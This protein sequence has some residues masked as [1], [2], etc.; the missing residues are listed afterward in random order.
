MR[1]T[2]GMLTAG[3]TAPAARGLATW[4]WLC[5]TALCV[6]ATEAAATDELSQRIEEAAR[7]ELV[8][9]GAPSMQIAVAH[10][11][12]VI[13]QGAYG[14]ADLEQKV[15]ANVHSRY[16]TASLSKWLTATAALALVELGKLDLDAPIQRYCPSFPAHGSPMTTRHLLRHESGIRHELDHEAAIER[17]ADDAARLALEVRRDRELLSEYTRYTDVIEPLDVFKQDA[18]LFEPGTNWSYSS[19]GYRVA[20]CVLEGASSRPYSDLIRELIL[21]RSMMKDTLPDDSWAIIPNRVAGYHLERGAPLRR[22]EMTDVSGNLPAGGHLSTAT[23]L[24]KFADAFITGKLVSTASI[25]LMLP[26]VSE[27]DWSGEDAWRDAIPSRESYG[28]G[29]MAFPRIQGRWIGH[30]G[31]QPGASVI[32]IASPDTR[33]SIAVMTN[34][35]GWNGYVSFI[36]RVRRIVEETAINLRRTA[37]APIRAAHGSPAA[38]LRADCRRDCTCSSRA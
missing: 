1:A 24:V 15:P 25:A 37:I 26:K 27:I 32:V 19:P 36:D 17:A 10:D 21:E 18:L 3:V 20:G 30:T 28:Y 4:L 22:A 14:F 13:F 34:V 35:K 16:R 8:E 38:P 23:D 12:R 9:S 29:V 2:E 11:G 31:R 33:M 6:A 5:C 7:Q